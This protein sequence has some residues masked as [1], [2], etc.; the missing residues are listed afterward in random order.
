[1]TGTAEGGRWA[2]RLRDLGLA[3][4]RQLAAVLERY[5]ESLAAPVAH[6]GGDTIYALDRHVE[7]VLIDQIERWAEPV[8]VIAEGF[9][10]EG[11]MEIGAS[12]GP[13]RYR[14][15][16][17][18]IDGTRG[19][20]YDKRSAWFLAAVARDRGEGTSLA[21]TFA[22]AMIELPTSKQAW[23]DSF[24]AW[25]GG[26][27]E[28][29]RLRVDQPGARPLQPRPSRATSLQD[30][31]AHVANFFPGTKVLA[32]ELMEQIVLSTVGVV[33]PGSGDVFDDQYISSGGQM[34]ELIL[35]HDRFCGDLRPLFYRILQRR[36]GDVS[37]GLEC[38]PY[39]VA[40]ALVAREAG[41]LITD[42]FDR[43]LDC[44]LNVH[45]PVHWCGYA[46]QALHQQIAPVIQ[47]W[48]RQQGL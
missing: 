37:A 23:A 45:Q 7:P 5:D 46:N 3:V 25:V 28:A 38:H 41:V 39:D 36:G 29:R 22:A 8:I 15:I 40:G 32:S 10:P 48:L 2:A 18:P 44:P 31:F 26:G 13:P 20:M 47:R 35:G 16:I 19:L 21:D 34:A 11:R 17:D 30:G 42:G 6:E 1:M 27:V 24:A 4:R 43:P 14:L 9:G 33:R 12:R